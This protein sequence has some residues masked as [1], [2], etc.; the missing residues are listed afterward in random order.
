MFVNFKQVLDSIHP[1]LPF[2]LAQLGKVFR[3]ES[4]DSGHEMQFYQLEGLMIGENVSVAN[5]KGVLLE[6][7]KRFF[8]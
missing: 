4:T 1:K 8:E 6:F 5:M 3:N 2:G 7:F